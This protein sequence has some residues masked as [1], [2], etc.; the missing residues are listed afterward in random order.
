MVAFKEENVMRW[1]LTMLMGFMLTTA[2]A[3]E[4]GLQVISGQPEKT[5]AYL[6][7]QQGASYDFR[8]TVMSTGA[9]FNAYNMVCVIQMAPDI[10]SATWAYYT[11]T[12]VNVTNNTF[13]IPI[14]NIQGPLGD[15]VYIV[16]TFNADE[17]AVIY[18]LGGGTFFINETTGYGS[19]VETDYH[20]LLNTDFVWMTGTNQFA[21]LSDVSTLRQSLTNVVRVV[22]FEPGHFRFITE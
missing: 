22:E 12:T 11:N 5:L 18:P 14:H 20:R 17:P 21:R 15:G 16:N 4:T 19:F 8:V 9:R 10:G 2:L 3:I 6:T 13:F 7:F 1:I